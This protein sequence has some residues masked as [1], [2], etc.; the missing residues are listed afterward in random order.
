MVL[1]ENL[2]GGDD[3]D[4]VVTTMNGGVYCFSTAASYHP[5]KAWASQGHGRNVMFP[6]AG[7]EGIHVLPSSRVP[8]DI[9]RESFKLSFEIVDT[10]AHPAQIAARKGYAVQ[11]RCVMHVMCV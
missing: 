11:V 8:R 9:G 10:R 7:H 3:L 4:L 1:A 6:L 2:D 5:L